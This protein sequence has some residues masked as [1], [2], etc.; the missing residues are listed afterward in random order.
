LADR[1]L[2][3]SY[4]NGSGKTLASFVPLIEKLYRKKLIPIDGLGAIVL[5]PVRELAM[6][7]FEVLN[8]FSL[9][10]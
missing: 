8:L 5:V 7:V 3:V 6:H 4:K 2:L 10:L 1:D 9:K